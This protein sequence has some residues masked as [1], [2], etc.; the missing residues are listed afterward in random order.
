MLLVTQVGITWMEKI[1]NL[2]ALLGDIPVTIIITLRNPHEAL[3]SL[4]QEIYHALP[5][6]LKFNFGAFCRSNWSSCY[7]F[8]FVCQKLDEVGFPHV[9]FIE[10]DAVSKGNISSREIFGKRDVLR[11]SEIPIRQ[12][13]S[14]DKRGDG[15]H[16]RLEK[17]SLKSFGQVPVIGWLIDRFKLRSSSLY[18]RIIK[19]LDNVSLRPAGY[20]ALD[21]PSRESER[22]AVG[23]E[24]ARLKLQEQ[25]RDEQLNSFL[26]KKT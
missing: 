20:R 17:V 16:R 24:V 13:N 26:E 3:P 7:D 15:K 25:L 12:V 11:M 9:R 6:R 4:Y 1:E 23:H 10:F 5:L 14:G 18:S 22:F 8:K 21:I 19:A 2:K